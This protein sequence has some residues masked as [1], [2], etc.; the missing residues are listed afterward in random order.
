M[1]GRRLILIIVLAALMSFMVSAASANPGGQITVALNNEEIDFTS[2]EQPLVINGC[3][4]LTLRTV[5]EKLG[6]EVEWDNENQ[7]VT[8]KVDGKTIMLSPGAKTYL[9]NGKG[10]SYTND[11]AILVDGRV[12]VPLRLVGEFLGVDV[13]W[14]AEERKIA[15]TS[16]SGSKQVAVSS[17]VKVLAAVSPSPLSYSEIYAR[18]KPF[19]GVPI[20]LEEYY[21]HPSIGRMP[22]R[23]EAWIMEIDAADLKPNGIR[24]G[25]KED[26]SKV[27]LDAWIEDNAAYIE[28]AGNDPVSARVVLA[29][30][31]DVSRFRFNAPRNRK[32]EY[33]FTSRYD[34]NYQP[35]LTYSDLSKADITKISHVMVVYGKQILAIRKSSMLIK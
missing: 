26:E 1:K 35:E 9:I 34:I 29:E 23:A 25:S 6:G 33:I 18:A 22:F 30:G 11:A 3:T 24:I 20:K 4:Y 14:N 32:N 7:V 15:I 17:D 28:Q 13:V 27:I 2:N 31:K 10:F 16:S 5:T 21:V 19:E 12:R 8:M